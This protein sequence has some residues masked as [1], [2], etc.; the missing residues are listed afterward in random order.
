MAAISAVL[1]PHADSTMSSRRVPLANNTAA[2]NSP[3]RT[4]AAV[5]GKRTRANNPEARDILHGQP[6]SKKQAIDTT[7]YDENTAP[8]TLTRQS[9][10]QQ[11]AEAKLFMRKPTNAAPTAFEKKLAAARDK[12]PTT[13][14][15]TQKVDPRVQKQGDSLETIRQWQKH[16][17][18]AFPQYVFYFE[19][20][21]EDVRSKVSR[22]IQYLGAKEEKFFSKS[23]THVVTTRAVPSEL[24]NTSPEDGH[25]ANSS[26]A[27]QGHGSMRTIDP[28]L[29]LD[30]SQGPQQLSGAQRKTANLLEA[31]L[32][33]RSHNAALQSIHGVEPRRLVAHNT[34]I[35]HKAR[36]LNIKIWALEKLQRMMTTMFDTDTGEQPSYL[37]RSHAA[38]ALAP[39]KRGKEA[40]L[41]QMLR[42]EK[43]LGPTDRDMGVAAQDMCQFRGYYLYVHDMDEKTRPVM[44][45][46]YPKAAPKEDGKWPQF[47]LTPIGRCPF[48]EDQAH[49]R[50][51]RQ[52]EEKA[53]E[54]ERERQLA[55]TAP[56]TRSRAAAV[57]TATVQ[58][59]Q[60]VLSERRPNTRASP[61]KVSQDA[62]VDLAKPLDPPK[63]LPSKRQASVEIG[64]MPPLFG[65]AQANMRTM[66]RLI[67]G[68][69]A[70]SGVQPSNITSA[71]RSQIVSSTAI[72]STAPGARAGT[73]KEIHALKRKVLERGASA[74]SN[75]TIHSSY[76]NDMRAA[77][78]GERAPPPRA[79]KRKAQET[80][81]H[82]H[83]DPEGEEA[84][85]GRR[86]QPARKKVAVERE[87]KPGYCENCRDKFDD[88]E[89]HVLTRKHRKF[90]LGTENWQQLDNLLRQLDRPLKANI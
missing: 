17:K 28:S 56:R 22:Q 48:I 37:T 72:S 54:E 68:E 69:P 2:V 1:S 64:S 88:F 35:L 41:Q 19:S 43:V 11:E 71:I 53:K 47:R 31:T 21:P 83:E 40:D 46:D 62:P 9:L 51:L 89:T 32:Q 18:K 4:I 30:R 23:V 84:G 59:Q 57:P 49:T 14:T 38:S 26:K 27:E 61:R 86:S 13:T 63:A 15:S 80:L 36:E 79:A 42:N 39:T 33:G 81:G 3:F 16:Y 5:S 55:I 66:P 70:A 29:L 76:L 74:N 25:H 34:D 8:R 6:P 75:G 87:L 90:A 7:E 58:S 77:I 45:R 44:V 78:N 60:G 73:S 12:K 65:S 20:V 82:I 50:K 24:A 10:A 85:Q 52:Q 67:G